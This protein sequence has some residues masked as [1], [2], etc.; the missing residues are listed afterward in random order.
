[1][2]EEIKTEFSFARINGLLPVE[3]KVQGT[4][5]STVILRL[6]RVADPVSASAVGHI[7]REREAEVSK[8]VE[9]HPAQVRHNEVFTE[10]AS[11]RK[12][13]TFH[14]SQTLAP[15]QTQR[16]TVTR[17]RRIGWAGELAALGQRIRDAEKEQE[18]LDDEV[19]ILEE[20]SAKTAHAAKVA[21]A[22]VRDAVSREVCGRFEREEQVARDTL[23]QVIAAPLEAMLRARVNAHAAFTRVESAVFRI[24]DLQ[25]RIAAFHTANGR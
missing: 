23:L 25:T 2:S 24:E 10:L 6:T 18:R 20:E 21:V 12:R 8:R 3:I 19:R 4:R 17:D 7:E 14:R 11:A 22:E 16:E 5:E 1:M 13:A 15:L 9:K